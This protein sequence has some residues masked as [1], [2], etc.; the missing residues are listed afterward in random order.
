MD[1][2]S[3]GQQ[4]YLF[5]REEFEKIAFAEKPNTNLLIVE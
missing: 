2:M 3:K 5:L 4:C 1:V